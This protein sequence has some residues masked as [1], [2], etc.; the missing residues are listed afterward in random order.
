MLEEKEKECL[1][2]YAVKYNSKA[3]TQ[4]SLELYLKK[5]KT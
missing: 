4:S 5:K 3:N 1:F 2:S